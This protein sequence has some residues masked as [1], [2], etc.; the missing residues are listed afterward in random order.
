MAKSSKKS[1]EASAQENP[2]TAP[3]MESSNGNH[4]AESARPAAARKT[5]AKPADRAKSSGES[6]GKVLKK[7]SVTRKPRA[8]KAAKRS[9]G[10]TVTD[11]Q[12][13]IRA[14][15]I[16]E[17][18]TQNGIAGDSAHDWLEAR[19]QLQAEAAPA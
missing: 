11:E 4:A 8:K 14:Y 16:A 19:R 7:A 9:S 13:R 5:A 12:I 15:F 3:G 1:K 10:P 17:R 18:R 2:S 6:R